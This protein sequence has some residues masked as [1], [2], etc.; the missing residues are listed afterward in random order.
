MGKTVDQV[1]AAV[2]LP[3]QLAASLSLQEFYGSVAWSVRAIFNQNLGWF[4]GNATN[5]IP[6]PAREK[7][8][9]MAALV[10]GA[11]ALYEKAVDAAAKQQF[12]WCLELSDHLLILRPAEQRVTKLRFQAL[13]A[14]GA[15][16]DN[17]N[18]RHYY[19][20][21][22]RELQKPV[23]TVETYSENLLPKLPMLG[24]FKRLAR[25]LDPVAAS[26]TDT[27]VG[28]IF[29]DTGE[30]YSLHVRRGVAEVQPRLL[31]NRDIT[32]T[33]NSL[34]MKEMLA[35][36]RSPAVVVARDMEV[37]G[38]KVE[39]NYFLGLFKVY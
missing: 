24:F 34:I 4:D 16:S 32:V 12:Q 17:A 6:L 29:P 28:F 1:V 2:K 14:L 8:Q 7:A 10:G 23:E 11:E 13:A 39:L 15:A 19:L 3:P 21:E 20:T 36:K 18:A 9:A 27:C 25:N 37:D 22:A 38:K 30:Q 26:E 33:V 31:E 35:K 5:L